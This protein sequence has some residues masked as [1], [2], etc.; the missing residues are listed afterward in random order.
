MQQVKPRLSPRSA[1]YWRAALAELHNLRS[2][3]FAALIVALSIVVSAFYIPVA[4]N[5]R[6]YFK[7]LVTA[8]GSA[9]YGPVMA[10]LVGAAA[11]TLGFFIH[12]SGGYFPGYLLSEV[13]G[14]VI[15]ALLLYRRRITVL[16]LF[17]ARALIDFGVNVALG[18][19]WSA[20]LYSK[21]YVFY[22]GASLVKNS[23]LLVP[24][25]LLLALLFSMLLP[26]LTRQNAVPP[27]ECGRLLP[28]IPWI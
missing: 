6:I 9:V 25:V 18:S 19:L 26:V 12:P 2:L 5:L 7:F 1:A 27:Q 21:G 3:V 15:F 4:D 13:L 23:L 17:L 28:R 10:A 22:A 11:D 14:N 16:R 20:M 24:E 8:A